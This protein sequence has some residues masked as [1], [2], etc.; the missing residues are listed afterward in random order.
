MPQLISIDSDLHEDTASSVIIFVKDIVRP[1]L[2]NLWHV[3]LCVSIPRLEGEIVTVCIIS[4]I[5]CS[6]TFI[7]TVL[8][9]LHSTC[10]GRCCAQEGPL[11]HH[12]EE[13]GSPIFWQFLSGPGEEKSGALEVG[14]FMGHTSGL[15][16]VHP[17]CSTLLLGKSLCIPGLSVDSLKQLRPQRGPLQVQSLRTPSLSPL[18]SEPGGL[19][20]PPP[21]PPCP[22]SSL[23]TRCGPSCL[24]R[25]ELLIHYVHH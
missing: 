17:A 23:N 13:P 4:Q 19:R 21:P 2:K 22:P 6:R 15:I 24:C 3:S 10:K 5:Q 18:H 8:T 12:Q 20:A 1:S 9:E 14:L 16:S 7:L 25:K 11:T